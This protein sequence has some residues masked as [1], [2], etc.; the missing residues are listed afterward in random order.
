MLYGLNVSDPNPAATAKPVHFITGAGTG[1]CVFTPLAFS[2]GRRYVATVLGLSIVQLLDTSDPWR[3]KT[4]Q[5]R[6]AGCPVQRGLA[7]RRLAGWPQAVDTAPHQR[8]LSLPLPCRRST[9]QKALILTPSRPPSAPQP[10]GR[11]CHAWRC[12]RLAWSGGGTVG[13]AHPLHTH[14][15]PSAAP[16]K[17]RNGTLIAVSQI[18]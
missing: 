11:A 6:G 13:T 12:A 3:F 14:R 18:V 15:P 8:F 1:S 7:E 9:C 17:R 10:G 16:E 4:L 2:G 5:A